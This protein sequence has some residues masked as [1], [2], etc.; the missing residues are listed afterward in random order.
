VVVD[1]VVAGLCAP[2]PRE[3]G[4]VRRELDEGGA[5]PRVVVLGAVVLVHLHDRLR[6]RAQQRDVG[7]RE[8]EQ[9]GDH[10]HRQRLGVVGDDV[11]RAGATRLL[12][13][14]VEQ[15]AAH[16]LDAVATGIDVAAGERL[17]PRAGA[18]GCA[19]AA[20]SRAGRPVKPVERLP[21]VL[22]LAR[23]EDAAEPS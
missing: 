6:P 11:E 3:V 22:R 19:W 17:W 14:G 4:D 16:L 1:E 5:R 23:G 20:R 8:A 18:A 13:G 12:V 21:D 2:R 7:V 9:V 15:V 10:E